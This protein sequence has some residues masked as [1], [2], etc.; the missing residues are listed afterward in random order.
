MA[1]KDKAGNLGE[2]KKL[3]NYEK[4]LIIGLRFQLAI[5][6]QSRQ[7]YLDFQKVSQKEVEQTKSDLK[8]LAANQL[9]DRMTT[10]K[11]QMAR[12]LD[13]NEFLRYEVFAGSGENIRYQVA[14]GKVSNETR[15]PASIKPQKSLNWSFQGEFWEDEI[16]NY[17]SSLRNNCPQDQAM[18]SKGEH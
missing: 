4:E 2:L 15:I 6:E 9:M 18:L 5:L 17:R 12:V 13:N 14:G 8:A 16:G 10:M 7:G 11:K 1:K 3:F